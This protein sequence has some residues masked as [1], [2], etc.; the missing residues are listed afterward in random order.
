MGMPLVL[1]SQT[2]LQVGSDGCGTHTFSSVKKWL[3]TS[4][5]P[6]SLSEPMG[7]AGEQT[8]RQASPLVCVKEGNHY[9][10]PPAQCEE[11]REGRGHHAER[12]WVSGRGRDP[13]LL[14]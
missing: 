6:I 7:M 2:F 13:R 11:R 8:D 3:G 14:T 5:S 4:L 12:D 9:R 1:V 10:L